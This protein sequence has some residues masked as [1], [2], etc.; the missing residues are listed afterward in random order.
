MCA[1]FQ[2]YQSPKTLVTVI[3]RLAGCTLQDRLHWLDRCEEPWGLYVAKQL[4]LDGPLRSRSILP[5][6]QW[7]T[8][9]RKHPLLR[10]VLRRHCVL[11]YIDRSVLF[12]FLFL[13]SCYCLSYDALFYFLLV[14]FNHMYTCHSLQH[15]ASYSVGVMTGSNSEHCC[16]LKCL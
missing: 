2:G 13:N 10:S 6:S 9:L 16:Q 14:T 7:E 3:D 8:I 15:V 5:S 11:T 4:R 1:L 12:F